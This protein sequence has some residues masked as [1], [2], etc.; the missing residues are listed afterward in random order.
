MLELGYILDK[1]WGCP[2]KP[3]NKRAPQKKKRP[4][5][6]TW[7][8]FPAVLIQKAQ[9]RKKH[10]LWSVPIFETSANR[11]V[12]GLPCP[13]KSKQALKGPACQL[14]AGHIKPRLFLNT[15][16]VRVP[17]KD[18]PHLQEDEELGGVQNLA[19]FP[20]KATL[21]HSIDSIQLTLSSE[22]PLHF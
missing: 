7:V 4:N 18:R 19:V 17:P 13:C 22:P 8:F 2:L 20:K 10:N 6:P 21:P 1:M 3:A 15:Y 9:Q 16:P 12:V 5:G 14:K 11:V